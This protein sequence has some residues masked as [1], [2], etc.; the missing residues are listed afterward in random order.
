MERVGQGVPLGT[1][2]GS[3]L[4]GREV[5]LEEASQRR[6]GDEPRA[7]GL[8]AREPLARGGERDEQHAGHAVAAAVHR[9][10]GV[11]DGQGA[12]AVADV[13]PQAGGGVA[14]VLGPGVL[15]RVLD[16]GDDEPRVEL[17]APAGDRVVE[18]EPA[19][20]VAPA[21]GHDREV[22]EQQHAGVGEPLGDR[23]AAHATVVACDHD[24]RDPG[25]HH[26]L[27]VRQVDELVVGEGRT[28]DGRVD[29]G[30]RSGAR[31][32]HDLHETSLAARRTGR[33]GGWSVGRVRRVARREG[34]VMGSDERGCVPDEVRARLAALR[35]DAL[36]Q[37]RGLGLAKSDLVEAVRGANV[38]DEHDPEGQTIAFERA[39]VDALA[40]EAR[41]RLEEVDAALARLED[42]T[43]GTC[44]V[45]GEP[46]DPARLVARPTATTCVAHAGR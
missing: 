45:G 5:L 15:V 8:D 41:R 37:L 29:V 13:E 32:R 2:R 28:Q 21:A 24:V 25:V 36:D 42:G 3:T 35:A 44:V 26:R 14:V 18:Q 40:S 46:I 19:D 4:R 23:G 9:G 1:R 31:R 7:V 27:Q 17:V 43:Y 20:T 6:G 39:Q 11:G 33:L 34:G 16:L 38:D 10:L 30:D 12:R 22:G